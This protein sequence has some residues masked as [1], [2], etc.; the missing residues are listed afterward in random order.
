MIVTRMILFSD[1]ALEATILGASMCNLQ[2]AGSLVEK[3][4]FLCG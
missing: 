3:G 4:T 1:R 2:G